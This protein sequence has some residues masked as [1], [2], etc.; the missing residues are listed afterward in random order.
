MSVTVPLTFSPMKKVGLVEVAGS[1][2]D[3]SKVAMT[4]TTPGASG[5]FLRTF[6]EWSICVKLD[7][8]THQ[9]KY[10]VDGEWV[11]DPECATVDNNLGGLNNIVTVEGK[12]KL[13]SDSSCQS[14]ENVGSYIQEISIDAAAS[15]T[16]EVLE[17][18]LIPRIS[19]NT[20]V[21]LTGSI[22]LNSAL[23]FVMNNCP[24]QKYRLNILYFD[25]TVECSVDVDNTKSQTNELETTVTW[26]GEGMKIKFAEDYTT[27][28]WFHHH[29][30]NVCHK[31]NI[32]VLQCVDPVPRDT[33]MITIQ[34]AIANAKVL[35][36]YD[37]RCDE[38]V[39]SSSLG[40]TSYRTKKRVKV[41]YHTSLSGL[42]PQLLDN[43]LTNTDCVE[44]I[45]CCSLGTDIWKKW[46]H[47]VETKR[48]EGSLVLRDIKIWHLDVREAGEYF[49]RVASQVEYVS[50]EGCSK[51]TE[52]QWKQV[53]DSVENNKSVLRK[54]E[55]SFLEKEL[56]YGVS[57]TN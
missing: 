9:Y 43:L 28:N 17:K 16:P 11:V 45:N 10:I 26:T 13:D 29:I 48:E 20:K 31:W 53:V 22:Q 21:E 56:Y 37:F 46:A 14:L 12:I 19:K 6:G 7:P 27:L 50:L 24:N 1:Y 18:F 42:H 57:S 39:Q 4:E 44:L 34:E 49:A 2:N 15:F 30:K 52:E 8:G 35:H 33:T 55:T 36:L 23:A 54:F 41:D 47:L 25:D 40:P 32:D 5:E 3:W 38:P 51:T